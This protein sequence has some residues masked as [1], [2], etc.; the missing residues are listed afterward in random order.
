MRPGVTLEKV[1]P[2]TDIHPLTLA[3]HHFGHAP[4]NMAISVAVLSTWREKP[5]I[6][7]C[8]AR[9]AIG[10]IIGGEGKSF[11]LQQR[12]TGFQGEVF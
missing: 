7:D 2:L 8:V 1:N 5:P 6:T 4:N 12:V 10:D 9:S 3:V 11:Q